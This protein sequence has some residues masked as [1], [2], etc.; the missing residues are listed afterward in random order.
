[1]YPVMLTERTTNE[2]P[3][4]IIQV[5]PKVTMYAAMLMELSSGSSRISQFDAWLPPG[6]CGGA[7]S[8]TL[9]SGTEGGTYGPV[10]GTRSW[11]YGAP[12]QVSVTAV[13]DVSV[14]DVGDEVGVV[15]PSGEGV[16]IPVENWTNIFCRLTSVCA[17]P[18]ATACVP[19]AS[20]FSTPSTDPSGSPK[21]PVMTVF[22]CVVRASASACVVPAQLS[23]RFDRVFWIWVME[24]ATFCER[25]FRFVALTASCCVSTVMDAE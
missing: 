4:K 17:K 2:I 9:S 8:A 6:F 12:H 11:S 14:T 24:S 13:V 10:G 16:F 7:A 1:M 5:L 15:S 19:D 18:A 20:T 21:S 3:R 22:H 25:F 23:A